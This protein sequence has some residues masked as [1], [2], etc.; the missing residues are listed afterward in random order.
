MICGRLADTTD[1]RSVDCTHGP[2]LAALIATTAC[3]PATETADTIN[4]GVL[5]P[6]TGNQAA[7]GSSLE[8]AVIMAVETVNQAG[9]V[10]GKPVRLV[11]ADTHSDPQRARQSLE[12]LLDQDV[13]AVVGPDSVDVAEA[14]LP[15]LLEEQV[16]LLSPFLADAVETQQLGTY[17]WFRL[18]PSARAL[19]EAI[20]RK[21]SRDGHVQAA[22]AYSQNRYGEELFAATSNRFVQL[23][24]MVSTSQG[25]DATQGSYSNQVRALNVDAD[26]MVLLAD[27]LPA[28]L[29][30][31]ELAVY[32][33]NPPWSWYLSPNLKN[34]VFLHNLL[35]SSLE[36]AVGVAPALDVDVSSFQRAYRDRFLGDEA[37]EGVYFYYDATVLLLLAVQRAM[38]Q[39]GSADFCMDQLV[40]AVRQVAR[41]TGITTRWDEV[42]RALGLISEGRLAYYTGVT[43]PILLDEQ[44]S[45]TLGATSEWYITNGDITDRGGGMQ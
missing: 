39:A 17:P 43:G 40:T 38:V 19:G 28:A 21:M 44:G 25:L 8:R 27:P 12:R 10:G 36:G 11:Y 9:G 24:G 6:Y 18:A 31:N 34:D 42:Q 22:F 26:A 5:L 37:R 32:I 16:V 45:R 14:I 7:I 15:R 4:V 20:A 30:V 41:P 3:G 35:G 2:L 23:G 29:L 33:T 1:V 13:V